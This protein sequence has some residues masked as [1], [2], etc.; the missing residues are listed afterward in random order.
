MLKAKVPVHVVAGLLGHTPAVL[1]KVYAHVIG[2]DRVEG[3]EA[4][5]RALVH[6]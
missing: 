5:R 6:V 4:L 1:M 2:D 3:I